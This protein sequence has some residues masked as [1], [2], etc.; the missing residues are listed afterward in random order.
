MMYPL[1]KNYQVN[2]IL[3]FVKKKKKKNDVPSSEMVDCKKWVTM[4]DSKTPF[5]ELDKLVQ[6]NFTV[7]ASEEGRVS[8]Y[9][10]Q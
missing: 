8:N 5:A 4:A 7:A 6:S 3:H 1:W 9:P 2:K 10:I